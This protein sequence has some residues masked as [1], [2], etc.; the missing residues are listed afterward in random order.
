MSDLSKLKVPELRGLAGGMKK[1]TPICGALSK[2]R[3]QELVDLINMTERVAKESPSHSATTRM[4]RPQG[5]F[6]WDPI[7][8]RRTPYWLPPKVNA[9]IG[10]FAEL[11]SGIINCNNIPAAMAKKIPYVAIP[12]TRKD[13]PSGFSIYK[14]GSQYNPI[15]IC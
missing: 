12:R 4:D 15:H 10:F 8:H 2:L 13:G 9:H 3:N 6:P 1:S 7:A 14:V 11:N 5:K